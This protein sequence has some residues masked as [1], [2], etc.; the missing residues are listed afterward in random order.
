[1]G[2][3]SRVR[4]TGLQ[5]RQQIKILLHAARAFP[6]PSLTLSESFGIAQLE[7]MA[8][9]LPVVNT[10][11]ATAVPHVARHG[12]EGL[13]VPPGD[14]DALASA[15]TRLL[16]DKE[17]AEKFGRAAGIGRTVT[18]ITR[19]LCTKQLYAETVQKGGAAGRNADAPELV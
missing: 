4:L 16:N 14:A 15:L 12:V 17:L 10:A 3:N 18:S 1:M 7:A 6:F 2:L 13:T 8:A 11:L 5:E 19:P 9:G